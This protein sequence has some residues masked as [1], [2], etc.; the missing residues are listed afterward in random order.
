[1]PPG[2]LI[3]IGEK[4]LDHVYMRLIQYGEDFHTDVCCL[5]VP[6]LCATEQPGGVRWLDVYGLHDTDVLKQIA[7]HFGLPNMLVEDILDTEQSPKVDDSHEGLL[8]VIIKMFSEEEDGKL[9]YEQVS[10]VLG[11]DFVITFQERPGDGFDP[12]RAR[13]ERPNSYFRRNGTEYLFYTILDAIMDSYFLTLDIVSDNIEALEIELLQSQHKHHLQEMYSLRVELVYLRRAV[14]PVAEI[15]KYLDKSSVYFTSHNER[16]LIRDVQDSQAQLVDRIGTYREILDGMM[17]LFHSNTNA[18]TNQVL[19]VL[20]IL[21]AIF[22]PM[23]FITSLY[24][25]NFK[26]MPE[27]EY[28]YAYYIVLCFIFSIGVG[29][30]MYFRSK[31]WL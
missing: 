28:E 10:L 9:D 4:K 16:L 6:A 18:N 5:D 2:S 30:F 14:L 1:M 24:G 29:L 31:K 25:M 7:E 19:S 13:I 26:Y 23:T 12:L 27:L 20:T 11:P 21:S 17:D 8:F 3:H 22:I 15:L